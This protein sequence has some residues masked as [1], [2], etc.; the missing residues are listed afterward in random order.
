[1]RELPAGLENKARCRWL[2]NFLIKLVMTAA[3]WAAKNNCLQLLWAHPGDEHKAAAA[4]DEIYV[5][6]SVEV[7]SFRW[8]LDY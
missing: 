4:T 6:H 5:S 2:H 8:A 1:M 7:G 3:D